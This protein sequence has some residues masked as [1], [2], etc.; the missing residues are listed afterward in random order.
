VHR[1][2]FKVSYNKKSNIVYL[3]YIADMSSAV[4]NWHGS[5]VQQWSPAC[6]SRPHLV[7]P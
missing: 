6:G 1:Q 3:L 4:V 5:A 2:N 7:S